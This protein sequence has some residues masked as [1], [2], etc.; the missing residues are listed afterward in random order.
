[1]WRC[2]DHPAI[3]V[4]PA[5]GF[6]AVFSQFRV[7][8]LRDTPHPKHILLCSDVT[9]SGGAVMSCVTSRHHTCSG[10]VTFCYK[11]SADASFE[12]LLA[13]WALSSRSLVHPLGSP[14]SPA[15]GWCLTRVGHNMSSVSLGWSLLPSSIIIVLAFVNSAVSPKGT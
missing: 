15:Y 1:M 4:V 5:R 11:R 8:A 9:L 3:R 2:A 14:L 6:A 12:A 13:H 7:D 10:H